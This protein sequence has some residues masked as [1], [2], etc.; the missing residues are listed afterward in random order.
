[1]TFSSYPLKDNTQNLKIASYWGTTEKLKPDNFSDP[2]SIEMDQQVPNIQDLESAREKDDQKGPKEE[3]EEASSLS[4]Q[5]ESPG[6]SSEEEE[7]AEE[8]SD[9]TSILPSSVLDK[10]SAI[11]EHFVCATRRSS[12]SADVCPS[13]R[14]P[15]RTGSSLSL[16]D[17]HNR[18]HRLAS[19]C[20][21]ESHGIPLTQ[22]DLSSAEFMIESLGDDRLFDPD[23]SIDRRRDSV[24]SRQDQLLIDK[25]RS[26]YENAEHQDATFSLKRRESLTYI[27]SGLVRNSVSR[28]NSIP[29]DKGLALEKTS[30]TSGPD[31]AIK[32]LFVTS[33]LS[34]TNLSANSSSLEQPVSDP[35]D[36]TRLDSDV[37]GFMKPQSVYYQTE[38]NPEEVFH[39]SSEMIKVWQEME[40][41]VNRCQGDL[42][43][44]RPRET[45]YYR[46]MSPSLLRK[47]PNLG[48]K[49]QGKGVDGQVIFEDSN[50][51]TIREESFTPSP[52][53][54]KE[55]R[56]A[57][58]NDA[59]RPRQCE[60]GCRPLT[61]LAPRVNRL[62]GETEDEGDAR[63]QSEEDA[64]S[65]QNKVF[66]LARKYSQRI[67]CTQPVLRQRSEESGDTWLATRNLL[68]VV[69]EKPEETKGKMDLFDYNQI[70][71]LKK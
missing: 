35:T 14:L 20:S 64:D 34:E 32:P 70:F 12:I 17:S 24:L 56:A 46:G 15:S 71:I 37:D 44:L 6:E 26:Y 9:S 63:A 27:P 38:S 69:E 50:L 67:K 68:S 65:S 22:E 41:E 66:H 7:N 29:N 13:P 25:I 39:P 30:N 33:A 57:S 23:Q 54:E 43:A 16:G 45:P 62:R 40:R 60:D 28:F 48:K 51:S 55:N 59:T 18:Q 53:K 47:S 21:P 5:T 36:F 42:K 1:M 10:A 52:L 19:T 8:K 11:A 49:T 58:E 3:T 4:Q 31:E 2:E 61:S